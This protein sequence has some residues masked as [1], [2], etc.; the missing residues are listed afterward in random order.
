MST[1][2]PHRTYSTSV[3]PPNRNAI[4]AITD[5]VKYWTNYGGTLG[6]LA[7]GTTKDYAFKELGGASF[8]FELGTAFN[9]DCTTFENTINPNNQKPLMHLAKISRAPYSMSQGPDITRLNVTEYNGNL[10]ITA[11][12]S[13]SAW[14]KANV[15]TAQ[16]AVSEIQAW[17]NIHPYALSDLGSS[18]S[19]LV[20]GRVNIDVTS[21]NPGRYSVYVQAMDSAENRGP[22][23]AV[24]FDKSISKRPTD[25]P[26]TSKPSLKRPTSLMPTP[27][28]TTDKPT[29]RQPT[30]RRPTTNKPST[31][32]PT[33]RRPT[34]R[35]PT[36]SRPT[37]RKPT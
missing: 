13:D 6:Y 17:V 2:R 3:L 28:P 35:R 29:T 24:F 20:N 9:Q 8:T 18:G 22:V 27:K 19:V 23:T 26:S 12:A 7:A 5:K 37:T 15:V 16:Q 36:T 31:R 1:I 4:T 30:T 11:I 33:T 32:K 34:T 21:M 14:S 10:T 25:S